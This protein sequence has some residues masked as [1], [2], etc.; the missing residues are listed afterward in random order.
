MCVMRKRE[1]KKG[2]KGGGL[3][4]EQNSEDRVARQG[5]RMRR[6]R[7]GG[8][9]NVVAWARRKAKEQAYLREGDRGKLLG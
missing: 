3:G 2:G 4:M 8:G 5:K 1:N 9:K 6:S 7:S